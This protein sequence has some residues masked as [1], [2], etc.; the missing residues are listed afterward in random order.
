MILSSSL[1]YKIRQ[2]KKSRFKLKFM[3]N[4]SLLR[5]YLKERIDWVESYMVPIMQQRAYI[6]VMMGT[7]TGT[8]S[9]ESL[10]QSVP[11]QNF[12]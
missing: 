10:M 6:V 5:Q 3:G 8:T 11:T 9:M 7:Q 4:R 1:L 2:T 12:G